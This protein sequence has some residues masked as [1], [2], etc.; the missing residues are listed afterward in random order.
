MR[1]MKEG[2]RRKTKVQHRGNFLD[3]G[4]EV[5]EGTPTAFPPLP[6]GPRNRLA[7]AKW[8]VDAQNPLTARVIANRFWEQIFGIGIVASSEEF[9]A[10]GELPSH[11]ELPDWLATELVR[12][13]WNQK[14]FL[15]L[16]VTS[17]AYQQSTKV[18]PELVQRDPENRLLRADP[19]S[20]C[21]RRPLRSAAPP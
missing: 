4:K 19:V 11:P 8:L 9:G 20:A 18:S 2:Q 12:L 3:L 10:Q 14:E 5:T 13:K 1:E 6:A 21:R 17:A 16:L 15:R 7:L